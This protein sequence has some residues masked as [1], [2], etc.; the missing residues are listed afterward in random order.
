MNKNL[1]DIVLPSAAIQ[2]A[3]SSG[4]FV[5]G[6]RAEDD[7]VELLIHGSIGE[8][9]QKLDSASVAQFLRDHRGKPLRIDINSPGGLAYDGVA[10]YNELVSHNAPITVLITGIAASAASIIAMAGDKIRIAE[11]GSLMIHRSWG[12]AVG[13]QQVMREVADLLE[14]LDQQIASTY[15]ARTGRTVAKMLQFM[16]ATLDGTTF[17]GRE[18]VEE[19]FADELLPLKKK[20]RNSANMASKLEEARQRLREAVQVRLRSLKI[21]EDILTK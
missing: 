17:S 9:W 5:I 2:Q 1:F 19:G 13:N 12:A 21:D 18:A 11:N 4:D 6:A 8:E 20:S 16:D 15:A 3:V 10:I 7:S 14:K